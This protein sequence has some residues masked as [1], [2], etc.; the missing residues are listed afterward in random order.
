VP[1]G[2]MTDLPELDFDRLFS[3][4]VKSM[5]LTA[6]HVVPLMRE[7]RSGAI[8]NTAS[9]ASFRPRGNM[10]WYGGSKGAVMTITQAMADE[11]APYGVRV[12]A[13]CPVSTETPMVMPRMTPERYEMFVK[14]IPLGRFG[15]PDDVANA[16]VYL[17]SDEAAFITGVGLPVDG[18]RCI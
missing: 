14:T 3:V 18:G 16:A 11:L 2:P 15:Q 7:Q 1:A 12:N 5:Y 17:L 10:V 9:S 13:V 8:L 4:N 6:R